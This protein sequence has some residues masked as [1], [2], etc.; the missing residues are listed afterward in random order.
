MYAQ[1]RVRVLNLQVFLE[2][3]CYVT[4]AVLI[5]YL[6][7]SGQYQSYVTPKMAPYFYFT[8]AVMIIWALGGLS[9]L[10]RPQHKTRAAHCFV[11]AIPII[12]L[13]LPPTPINTSD[14]PA[15]YLSGNTL[16]GQPEKSSYNTPKGQEPLNNSNFSGAASTP[17]DDQSPGDNNADIADNTP[18]TDT[19]VPANN[20]V[21]PSGTTV[22]DTQTDI[23]DIQEDESA[24]NLA[25]LDVK[26]KKITVA[27]D[28]FGLWLSAIYEDMEKYKGYTVIMT[29]YVY[30]DPEFTKSNEFVA[31]RLMMSCCVADLAPTGLICRYDKASELKKDSWV[32]VEGTLFI[33]QYEYDGQKYDDPQLIVTKITPTEKVEGYIYP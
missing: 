15:G 33:G 16:A 8:A 29:G 12:L 14:L 6:V 30:R 20:T 28:D 18:S 24:A 17:T 23:Q 26:N 21:V 10:F 2:F 11:L 13:L 1:K 9:R 31:A 3:V 22:S 4:F 7:S 27:N 25:G 19:P 32:T 5:F